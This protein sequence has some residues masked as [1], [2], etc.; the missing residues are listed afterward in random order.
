M[1]PL[2]ELV[3]ELQAKWKLVPP[4]TADLILLMQE[5]KNRWYIAVDALTVASSEVKNGDSLYPNVSFSFGSAFS[6]K[7]QADTII[8]I[9]DEIGRIPNEEANN[10]CFTAIRGTLYDQGIYRGNWFLK[11]NQVLTNENGAGEKL[12]QSV[13]TAIQAGREAEVLVKLFREG[14]EILWQQIYMGTAPEMVK[15]LTEGMWRG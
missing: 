4:E 9:L 3:E 8:S 1:N 12:K 5:I 2:N 15:K 11:L 7:R 6:Y 13:E 14:L 10:F